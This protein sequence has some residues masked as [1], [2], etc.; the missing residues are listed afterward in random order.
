MS[1][2]NRFNYSVL[3]VAFVLAVTSCADKGILLNLVAIVHK[4]VQFR[5]QI[6]VLTK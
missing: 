1:N 6:M 2:K 4:E 5:N 3:V